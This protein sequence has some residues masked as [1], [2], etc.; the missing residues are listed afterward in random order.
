M[1]PSARGAQLS[2]QHWKPRQRTYL[3]RVSYL[4]ESRETP[5]PHIPD[6]VPLPLLKNAIQRIVF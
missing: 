5:V 2:K 3:P 1:G 4:W 6:F